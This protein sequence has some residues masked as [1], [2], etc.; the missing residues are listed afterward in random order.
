MAKQKY[1]DNV[2][3]FWSHFPLNSCQQRKGLKSGDI[4]AMFSSHFPLN[5][6]KGKKSDKTVGKL[7]II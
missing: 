3:T 6:C 4:L 5:R 7:A 2:A 1:A